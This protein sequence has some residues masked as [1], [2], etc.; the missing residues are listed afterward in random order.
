MISARGARQRSLA[1]AR[2]AIGLRQ[3]ARTWRA[4]RRGV[5]LRLVKSGRAL[6]GKRSEVEH[7]QSPRP[8]CCVPGPKLFPTPAARDDLAAIEAR[9]HARS[10]AEPMGGL[11]VANDRTQRLMRLRRSARRA[12]DVGLY[13]ARAWPGG[14]DAR[15]AAGPRPWAKPLRLVGDR[16]ARCGTTALRRW[17]VT[18]FAGS[19]R[20]TMPRPP[21]RSTALRDRV[22][23]EARASV[24]RRA[25]HEG[26]APGATL[27]ADR[28]G[29]DVRA[30]GARRIE[31]GGLT[32]RPFCR[33]PWVSL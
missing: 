18:A 23:R 3:S 28:R 29:R 26:R 11:T 30:H 14:S 17:H 13:G 19:S 24:A 32:A 12:R 16:G 22:R 7:W 20:V 5:K 33:A 1:H 21:G 15:S 4:A 25:R 6:A 8:N 27:A 10:F 2:L 9:D 31:L